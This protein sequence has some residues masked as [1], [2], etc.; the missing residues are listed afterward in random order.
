MR[1]LLSTIGTRGEVQPLAALA[2]ELKAMGHDAVIC[3][4]PDFREWAR[5][6]GIG[7]LPVGP[8]LRGTAQQ[9]RGTAPTPEQRRLMIEGTVAAQ[10]E[11]VGAA[12]EGC[13]AIV[14]GGA[15]AVAA[16]SVAEQRGIAYVY[17]AFA[18]VTLPSGHHAPPVFGML[19]Q[20]PADGDTGNRALWAEDAA[21]WNALWAAPLD[22]HR[23]AAGLPPVEDVRAHIFTAAPWLAADP[24]L[25]PWP[26]PS[27]SLDVLQTGAWLLPDHRPLS[28]GTEAFLDAGDP[29]VYCGFGS[30]RAPDG[31]AGTVIATARALGRRVILSRG[32]AGLAPVDDGPDCLTI[33]EVNQRALFPRVA[34]VLHHGGAGTT[35]A[36]AGAPQV[37]FPQ[38]FDQF[39]FAGRVAR[40]GIGTAHP[41]GTPDAESLHAALRAAL[42][43]EVAA[44]ARSVAG[45]VRTDGARTAALRLVEAL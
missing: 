5:S 20:K 32:W 31:V 6:L 12:A 24:A 36:A 17:A 19:G 11:A 28:R 34:A 23:A 7:Y 26:G 14:A 9:G 27:A 13:D 44:R 3:A 22:A 33:G 16:R 18:P 29:P 35:T 15:L 43:P 40:L 8:E 25:A 10:F 30:M 2:V 21:R 37:V 4:P 45:A 1:C 42:T 38:M 41:A 39:Y